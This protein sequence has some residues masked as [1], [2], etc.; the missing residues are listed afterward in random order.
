M[1]KRILR[2]DISLVVSCLFLFLAGTAGVMADGQKPNQPAAKPQA[3]Q[4][5]AP[6]PKV[7]PPQAKP[8][9]TES[10]ISQPAKPAL[11]P[12]MTFDSATAKVNQRIIDNIRSAFSVPPSISMTVVS[13]KPAKVTGMETATIEINDGTHTRTQEVLVTND[14]KFAVIG[15]VFDL[16]EN[17]YAE[18]MKKINLTDVPM[19]GNKNAKVTI[20][21]FS[22]FQCPFCDQAYKTIEN[23]VMK[24]YG[25]KVRI[26]YKNFPLPFHPWA[27]D[28]AVAGLCAFNQSNDAFWEFYHDFFDNQSTITPQNVR[29][30]VVDFAGKAKLDTKKFEDCYDNKLTLPRIKAEM[31]E[32]QSLGITGTPL[33]VVNGHPLSGVQPF[34]NFQKIIDEELKKS[35][36]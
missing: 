8:A 12:A 26:V 14:N 30:K 27:E 6:P 16:S 1:I 22:D 21:E 4:T 10:S 9:P 25:D 20:V 18:N 7:Q 33:F 13:R 29:E 3:Q 28:A 23:D 32:G 35:S 17:P 15:R 31:A 19:R 2:S 34:S 36:D 11:P 5:Q 24:Q